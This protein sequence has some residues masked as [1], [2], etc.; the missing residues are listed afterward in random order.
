MDSSRREKLCKLKQNSTDEVHVI[1]DFRVM[2]Q[3]LSKIFEKHCQY[4][5][6]HQELPQCLPA[7][8]LA[9]MR[10]FSVRARKLTRPQA[11]RLF[12]RYS[13]Q[14]NSPNVVQ[15]SGIRGSSENCGG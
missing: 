9:A 3:A 5:F 11:G 2:D 6:E 15:W 8:Y 1:R 7:S 14:L 4:R 13:I 10:D 12:R